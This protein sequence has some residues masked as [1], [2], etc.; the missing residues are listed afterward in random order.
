MTV[1]KVVEIDGQTAVLLPPEAAAHLNAK[2]GGVLSIVRSAGGAALLL[3]DKQTALQM[4]YAHELMR[5][6]PKTFKTLAT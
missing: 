5:D 3:A 4:G 2:P 6:F 1:V